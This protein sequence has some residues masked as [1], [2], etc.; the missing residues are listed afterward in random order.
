MSLG[1]R[2]RLQHAALLDQGAARKT[3]E[4]WFMDD[5]GFVYQQKV[6][7]D[8]QNKRHQLIKKSPVSP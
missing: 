6:Q 7:R 2:C 5:K 4:D 1:R 8:G 3:P